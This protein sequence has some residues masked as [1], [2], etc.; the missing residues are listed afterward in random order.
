M[1]LAFSLGFSSLDTF[2]S[3]CCVMSD[4]AISRPAPVTARADPLILAPHFP[5]LRGS[6]RIACMMVPANRELF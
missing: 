5:L 6:K 1:A 3:H 2:V 4:Q